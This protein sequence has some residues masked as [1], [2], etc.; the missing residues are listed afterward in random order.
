MFG[1]ESCIPVLVSRDDDPAITARLGH[2]LRKH[3]AADCF[4]AVVAHGSEGF[5][6]VL[7]ELLSA[8]R[9]ALTVGFES[10]PTTLL[11]AA[12]AGCLPHFVTV[13]LDREQPPG[14]LRALVA[15]L[16]QHT[17]RV[18]DASL[19]D[20]TFAG[21][22]SSLGF[23]RVFDRD[24][25]DDPLRLTTAAYL[26][27]RG[28]VH[29]GASTSPA[30]VLEGGLDSALQ[31]LGAS[32]DVFR[33][34]APLVIPAAFRVPEPGGDGEVAYWAGG[35][36]A[37][38]LYLEAEESRAALGFRSS[39][40]KEFAALLGDDAEL[41]EAGLFP[42]FDWGWPDFSPASGR[43]M[44]PRQARSE[45]CTFA[46]ALAL[47]LV[48]KV[49]FALGLLHE[50]PGSPDVDPK[51]NLA[52]LDDGQLKAT[53]DRIDTR[54]CATL[55]LL[56]RSRAE[57]EKIRRAFTALEVAGTS[58][59]R[60]T[61][62]RLARTHHVQHADTALARWQSTHRQKRRQQRANKDPQV[63]LKQLRDSLEAFKADVIGRAK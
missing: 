63:R 57:P 29:I 21:G 33:L 14:Q 56:A 44:P 19:A 62:I 50:L 15:C 34:A 60:R 2:E 51:P 41:A 9:G 32:Q 46:A 1:P 24:G 55:E 48:D 10:A 28:Y 40:M 30:S 13:R 23:F 12:A 43:P 39:E 5:S 53:L 20:P 31:S 61:L 26:D 4:I 47:G 27:G 54:W 22:L 52:Y 3:H 58:E 59:A 49:G 17:E 16:H 25:D 37:F 36:Q 35:T 11:D 18:I 38:G 6:D 8:L 7:R 45:R 42:A